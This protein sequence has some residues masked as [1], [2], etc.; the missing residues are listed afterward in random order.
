MKMQ[1][2][3]RIKGKNFFAQPKTEPSRRVKCLL[4]KN[5]ATLHISFFYP[6]IRFRSFYQEQ[7][8]QQHRCRPVLRVNV[9]IYER[10]N[11]TSNWMGDHFSPK[12][13][14]MWFLYQV[15]YCSLHSFLP[16][17]FFVKFEPNTDSRNILF[18]SLRNFFLLQNCAAK[19]DF[20]LHV[21]VAPFK[22]STS[23][24]A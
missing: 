15:F 14:E 22:S 3:E 9:T 13:S 10:E 7:Q 20:L 17:V 2:G 23:L 8:H 1:W 18:L 12:M 6:S 4:Y 21:S 19:N 5:L 16:R 11:L 24:I